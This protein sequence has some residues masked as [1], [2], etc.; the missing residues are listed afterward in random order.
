MIERV[1][2]RMSQR[3]LDRLQQTLVQLR[4]LALHLQPNAAAQPQGEIADNARHLGEDVETGC[5]RAFITLSRRSAVTMSRR[6]DSSVIV[7]SARGGLQNLVAGQHQFA[8]QIHHPVQQL[9]VHAQC[10]V[11]R[12]PRRHRR[13][14]VRPEPGPA[15]VG[16]PGTSGAFSAESERNGGS[17]SRTAAPTV[18]CGPASP[19][20]STSA[21]L[22][23]KRNFAVAPA[24]GMSA[25]PARCSALCERC[26]AR[27]YSNSSRH[28]LRILDGHRCPGPLQHFQPCN[29][30]SIGV[31]ARALA[32][33]LPQSI[34]ESRA[35]RPSAPAVR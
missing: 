2:H 24:C 3:I 16:R 5:I 20:D 31:F 23:E 14:R 8:H 1:A 25:A 17:A 33:P 22:R 29:H 26:N 7:G 18:P 34:A 4:V 15:S 30:R 6:R 21:I 35:A 27:R 13:A 12:S 28:Q 19:E 11:S 32:A 10:G 9:H